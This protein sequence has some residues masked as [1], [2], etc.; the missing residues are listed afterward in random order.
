MAFHQAIR[1]GSRFLKPSN[2]SG[3][4]RPVIMRHKSESAKEAFQKIFPRVGASTRL[5]PRYDANSYG[6]TV[7]PE[8]PFDIEKTPESKL[9]REKSKG[10]I[11]SISVDEIVD[12]LRANDGQD[13]RVAKLHA[14]LDYAEH[15][16]VV[17]GKNT[18]HLK[19]MTQDL[20]SKLMA[21]HQNDE[22][23]VEGLG[24]FDWMVVDAGQVVT[25]LFL[26]H[27]REDYNID[28]AWAEK[29]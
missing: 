10:A 28:E 15:F 13:I 11:T 12:L 17:S 2:I 24:S 6:Q 5:R 1:K 4:L 27:I 26:P 3:F 21:A 19:A 8:Y 23:H 22:I 25:H 16:I 14:D 20:A 29:Q 9:K 7:G 18:D